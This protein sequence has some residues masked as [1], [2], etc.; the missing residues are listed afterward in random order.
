MLLLTIATLGFA[1]LQDSTYNLREKQ[2]VGAESTYEMAAS[3]ESGGSPAEI[4]TL[5][6]IKTT[7][8]NADSSFEQEFKILGGTMKYDGQEQV[9]E[10]QDSVTR[11]FDKD[12]K[13]IKEPGD[14]EVAE[15][16]SLMFQLLEGSDPA[17]AVKLGH[18]WEST[19]KVG[20]S[21][22]EFMGPD[23][24][25]DI[26]ALKIAVDGELTKTGTSGDMKAV[27]WVRASDAATQRIEL[28]CENLVIGEGVPPGKV[29]I[30]VTRK[31]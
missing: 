21:K 1:P 24:L 8:V 14:E 18:K 17:E 22:F 12:G 28:S 20:K 4:K 5:Y 3:L 31:K 9:L 19:S 29:K 2:I 11:K 13:E 23:K 6:H 16:L 10:S 7:K 30:V 15:P 25:D 26:D 27:A